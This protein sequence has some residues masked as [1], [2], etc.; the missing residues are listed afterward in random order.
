MRVGWVGEVH[1]LDNARARSEAVTV[2]TTHSDFCRLFK[3]D[4]RGLYALS[5]VL[6]ADSELAERCFVA[7]LDDC[8]KGNPVFKNWAYAWSRRTIIMNAIRGVFSPGGVNLHASSPPKE[9]DWKLVA[10]G[11]LAAVVQ[12]ESLERF[13]FVMSLLEGYSEHECSILLNRSRR[14][15]AAARTLA[16][17]HLGEPDC[18]I[19]MHT[20]RKDIRAISTADL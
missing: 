8:I 5:L 12:L 19:E 11:P 13:V 7:G 16:L 15:I 4:M 18:Y 3:E 6:T 1:K 9:D 2:Y 10:D 20:R 17:Q 14:E